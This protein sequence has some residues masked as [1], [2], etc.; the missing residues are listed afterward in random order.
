MAGRIP[1]HFIDELMTRVDIVEVIDSRVPLKKAG[2][3][4]TACCPFHNEKTPSF[5]V[6]SNKQFYHCFG[7]G[8]HGTA[9]GF[10]ME[11]EHLSF[12]EAVEELARQVGLEVPYEGPTHAEPQQRQRNDNLYDL[13]AQ[14]DRYY[15][16]QL[17]QHNQGPRAVDYLKQ[18]GLSGEIAAEF[19]LGFAPPGWDNLQRELGTNTERQEQLITTGMLI[20]K[21]DGKSYDR[22]RDRIMFPIRD[23]RG[24]TIAFGGRILPDTQ[25]SGAKAPAAAQGSASA[26][27][28]TTAGM[29]EVEQSGRKLPRKPGAAKY[30]N[31]P[32][33]PLFHKGQELYGLYEARQALRDIPRL[34]VVEGYMDVVALAQFDIRYAV[35]T[36]GTATT[37]EHLNRLFRLTPEVVFCFDGDRAGRDAA[38]RA[39]NNALPIMREGRQIRFMFL[40]EGDDPDTRVRAVGK[41]GFET[42]IKAALNFSEFFFQHLGKLADTNS[43][44]GRAQLVEQARPLLKLLPP[45]VFRHMMTEQLA[46]LARLEPAELEALL[47][48]AEQPVTASKKTPGHRPAARHQGPK[49]LSP[50]RM[51]LMRLLYR[52]ELAQS[53]GQPQRFAELEVPGIK[54]LVEVLEIL[55][56]NP[57]LNSSA[58]LERL[59]GTE[60]GSH[61]E[62]LATWEPEVT[63]DESL[64][65]EFRGALAQLDQQQLEHRYDFLLAR[66]NQ[67]ELTPEEKREL[68]E[69]F[70]TLNRD[71]RQD[72]VKNRE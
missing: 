22:F 69:L 21:D 2:R 1:Q 47:S 70:V 46:R 42:E 37:H 48:R 61:L 66:S 44:D 32:E 10:L 45:G 35:A 17:R 41:N 4:H 71:K 9:V 59:R 36:L 40:P 63:T 43:I 23:R 29:Q 72:A 27:G 7:C 67:G 31:S 60:N 53:A 5:T 65:Q 55:Q 28:G 15:R 51:A 49:P 58:L 62:K 64:E 20:R 54:L 16:R 13:L 30:L 56:E 11:Y 19:G 68:Q 18:R 34:L 38:W 39:L 57:K 14:S 6:S 26:A 52:P 24:R 3:E 8:A 33:T 12:P 50:V 25:E